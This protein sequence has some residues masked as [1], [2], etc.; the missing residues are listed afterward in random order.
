MRPRLAVTVATV[1]T[2]AAV[3]GCGGGSDSGAGGGRLTGVQTF[4]GLSHQ[5]VEGV[6]I[7]YP[8]QPPVG[9]PHSP[10]WLRCGIYDAPVPN[11]NAV[12]SME[13]GAVW[14]TYRPGLDP[15]QVT[16]LAGLQQLAPAYFLLSPYPDLPAPVVASTWGLQLPVDSASDPR[17]AEF[18]TTYAGGDQG[19]EG[20]ADCAHGVTPDQARRLL[21]G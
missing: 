14:V 19:G 13:H 11:E 12:H 1:V 6:R 20:G 2:A 4:A 21:R 7:T 15:A 16:T 3:G 5:H 18:V 9:G 8:Q 17:L 10:V